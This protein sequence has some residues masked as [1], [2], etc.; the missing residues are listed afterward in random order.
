MVGNEEKASASTATEAN[1]LKEAISRFIEEAENTGTSLASEVKQLFDDLTEKISGIA[2]SAAETTVSMAEKVAVK[3]PAELMR[4]LLEEVRQAGEVSL[5][6]IGEQFDELRQR[7]AQVSSGE[8]APKTVKKRVV[9][10]KA[11]PK[12]SVPK[13][14]AAKKKVAKKTP[15]KKATVKKTA[16]KK[17]PIK[18]RSVSKKTAKKSAVKKAPVKKPAARKTSAR[19]KVANKPIS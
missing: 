18:K 15:V 4:N 1:K 16:A 3:D 17:A 14:T 7:V 11:A 5:Q 10:K 19:K 12:K 2:A 13:K 6:A 9:K 8:A